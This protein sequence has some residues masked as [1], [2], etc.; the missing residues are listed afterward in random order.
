MSEGVL[1]ETASPA[2][3]L[4]P[5]PAPTEHLRPL[6]KER[7]RMV[8]EGG[9]AVLIWFTLFVLYASHHPLSTGALVGI[10]LAAAIWLAALRSAALANRLVPVSAIAACLGATVGFAFVGALNR[11]PLGLDVSFGA[12]VA[13][14]VCVLCSAIVWDW[15][16]ERT[17]AT[18][19]RVLLVGSAELDALLTEELRTS[20]DAPYDVVG[21]IPGSQEL[22]EVI[23]AQSP[24]IVVL[25]DE[26]TYAAALDRVLDSRANVRVAGFASFF[27]YAFG[28]IPVDQINPAWFMSLLHPRQRIY[29][30]FTKRA[31]DLFAAGLGL[32]LAAPIMAVLALLTKMTRGPVLYRQTRVGEDGAHFTIYKFRTMRCDA[33]QD[34]PSFSCDD[35]ARATR[36]GSMLRRTHLDELPQLWNVLKGE[37]SIVGPRPERPEFIEMLESAVPFWSRRLLVKPGITGWA[38]VRCDYASDCEA[39]ERKL[40]YD[41]WYLRHRSLLVD[42]AICLRTVGLQLRAL[43][44][45]RRGNASGSSSGDGAVLP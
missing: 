15:F 33:E 25:T 43:L 18:R 19:R 14:A 8:A 13:F 16:A 32:V 20:R 39:M 12:L 42:V 17:L 21:A 40:S 29:A 31:F 6:S 7:T 45:T 9:R 1:L 26:T 27:E 3:A 37:M 11:S 41:L 30:R 23:A 2:P 35:D 36:I 4:G 10:T 28:R 44:P 22:A 5:L 38:Q 24:D 34:G